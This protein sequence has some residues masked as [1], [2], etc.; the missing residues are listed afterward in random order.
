VSAKAADGKGYAVATL[1]GES[2]SF[3]FRGTAVTWRT[4]T[5]PSSGKV[6]VYVDGVKK[7]VVD[8]WSKATTYHVDR[9]VTGLTD[10]THTL[11]LVV[12]G[13][14]NTRA[15]GTALALDTWTVS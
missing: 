15:K 3:R 1:K 4:V 6:A 10:G 5:G 11:K 7:A 13:T 14:K 8:N 9:A 2:V 12:T